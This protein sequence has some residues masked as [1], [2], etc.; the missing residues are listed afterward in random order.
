MA[1]DNI[2]RLP[3]KIT[4]FHLVDNTGKSQGVVNIGVNWENIIATT[5]VNGE[6]QLITLKELLL[7]VPND[8]AAPSKTY[9]DLGD[10]SVM[11]TM[12]DKQEKLAQRLFGIYNDQGAYI[13]SFLNENDICQYYKTPNYEMTAFTLGEEGNQ[14]TYY[15]P[16][17]TKGLNSVNQDYA[18][19]LINE[20]Y[21]KSF[22]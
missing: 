4:Q 13:G 10:K 2:Q 6:E 12:Y 9:Y 20:L 19:W 15:F 21:N 17:P 18:E 8:P 3:D 1:Q 7:R 22:I 14:K 16:V 5:I 11:Y